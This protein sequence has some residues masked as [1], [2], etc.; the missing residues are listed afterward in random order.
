MLPWFRRVDVVELPAREFKLSRET[1]RFLHWCA[2]VLFALNAAYAAL[3][4]ISRLN[5]VEAEFCDL[6]S[7][8]IHEF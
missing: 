8:R 6:N 7:P 5:A 4:M 2:G 1:S 3:I